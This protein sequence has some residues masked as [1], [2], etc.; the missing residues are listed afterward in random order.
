MSWVRMWRER[1]ARTVTFASK[2]SVRP[3]PCVGKQRKCRGG[4]GAERRG[5]WQ[6][7]DRDLDEEDGGVKRQEEC[8]SLQRRDHHPQGWRAHKCEIRE[9]EP[10][11]G[12]DPGVNS[13]D[14]DRSGI[15]AGGPDYVFESGVTYSGLSV[16]LPG[17]VAPACTLSVRTDSCSVKHLVPV[18]VVV[19]QPAIRRVSYGDRSVPI[20]VIHAFYRVRACGNSRMWVDKRWSLWS[21]EERWRSTTYYCLMPPHARMSTA[22][23]KRVQTSP[24]LWPPGSSALKHK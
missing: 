16:C 24:D 7:R 8:A 13:L 6:K 12:R 11:R 1:S 3:I 20:D 15:S 9:A 18:E 4:G 19:A 5:R 10:P 2:V 14:D 21:K 22:R 17:S 23:S